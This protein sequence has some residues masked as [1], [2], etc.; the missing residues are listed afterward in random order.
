MNVLLI[1]PKAQTGGLES[2][3][4]GHQILQGLLYVAAAARDQGHRAV[5]AIADQDDVD[6]YIRRYQPDI[7]GVSCVS[8]T[9]PIARDVLIH[10]KKKHPNLKTIIGGH[11]G[12]FLYKE[13]ILET[14]VDYVCRGEGRRG[15][16][17]STEGFTAR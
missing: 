15:V 8:A 12:T 4:K 17:C 16:C 9:Y 5:V 2:L 13:V 3:R 11:H 14:G 10:V 6:R 7:L 1:S